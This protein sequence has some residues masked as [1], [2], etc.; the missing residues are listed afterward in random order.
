MEGRTQNR[1]TQTFNEGE[2]PYDNS[3]PLNPGSFSPPL[4][5]VR[6]DEGGLGISFH[7]VS[8]SDCSGRS[9]RDV[10]ATVA[11]WPRRE[12]L[13]DPWRKPV[14]WERFGDWFKP[15]TWRLEAPLNQYW[16]WPNKDN[17]EDSSGLKDSSRNQLALC[18]HLRRPQSMIGVKMGE[19]FERM[20]GVGSPN[21]SGS[22]A[23]ALG[24]RSC[25]CAQPHL[26]YALRPEAWG[27]THL[28]FVPL[29]SLRGVLLC[30]TSL[31][32]ARL[33]ADL[34]PNHLIS[35]NAVQGTS[36]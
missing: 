21:S 24:E 10:Q 9:V 29:S 3:S 4:Y 19:C 34:T 7:F 20:G 25:L 22:A 18:N 13:G 11:E 36:N 23:K 35:Q 32:T 33:L 5:R 15:C 6:V 26:K 30:H 31:L 8:I 27:I 2:S 1:C 14:R 28:P 12:T 17:T 16:R